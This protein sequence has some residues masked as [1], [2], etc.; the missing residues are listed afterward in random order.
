MTFAIFLYAELQWSTGQDNIAA[1]VGF[2]DG[3]Y[4]IGLH[5]MVESLA[6]DTKNK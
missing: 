5:L 6:N 3:I 4:A 1:R 2:N